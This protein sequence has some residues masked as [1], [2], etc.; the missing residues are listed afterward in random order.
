MFLATINSGVCFFRPQESC[1]LQQII[2][3]DCTANLEENHVENSVQVP[4][5]HGFNAK[6]AKKKGSKRRAEDVDVADGSHLFKLLDD[7]DGNLTHSEF[8]GNHKLPITEKHMSFFGKV[9]EYQVSHFYVKDNDNTHVC[10]NIVERKQTL[11]WT[12]SSSGAAKKPN[13]FISGMM[14]FKGWGV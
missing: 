10:R 5:Y 14:R 12:F 8:L 4:H 9:I 3:K 6:N 11:S 2:F 7:G 1:T 13:R